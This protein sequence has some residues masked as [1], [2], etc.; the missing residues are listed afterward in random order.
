MQ[1]HNL[2]SLIISIIILIIVIILIII[3]CC[4]YNYNNQTPPPRI[5][6]PELAAAAYK[7][8][9]NKNKFGIYDP[10]ITI[11]TCRTPQGIANCA[12]HKGLCTT[13]YNCLTN[14]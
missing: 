12:E 1:E 13:S 14:C 9:M 3:V 11:G 10:C 2:A 7:Y 6:N 5:Q 8:G 4:G